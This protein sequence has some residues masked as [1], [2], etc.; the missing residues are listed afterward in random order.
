MS[1]SRVGNLGTTWIRKFP[2]L[3]RVDRRAG[4]ISIQ[5]S[6]QVRPTNSDQPA[7]RVVTESLNWSGDRTQP[8]GCQPSLVRALPAGAGCRVG[9]SP[10]RKRLSFLY[11]NLYNRYGDQTGRVLGQGPGRST[12]ISRKCA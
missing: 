8:V 1:G 6:G 11:K 4:N 12:D 2:S 9:L 10:T 3:L 7:E 5:R